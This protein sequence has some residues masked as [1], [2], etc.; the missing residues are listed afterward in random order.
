MLAGAP[1]VTTV[2]PEMVP[3]GPWIPCGPCGPAG[4]AGPAAPAAPA[5]PAGPA[6]PA[7]PAGPAAPAGPWDP[8][9]LEPCG[10]WGPA[11]PW[12]PCI[13]C[14]PAGPGGPIGPIG[15]AGPA[16]PVAP[17]APGVPEPHTL[18]QLQTLS[19]PG[20]PVQL[21][22]PL[23][24]LLA[25]C[26]RDAAVLTAGLVLAEAAVAPTPTSPAMKAVIPT[27]VTHANRRL[28]QVFP[29]DRVSKIVASMASGRNLPNRVTNHNNP[30][31]NGQL[32]T[33]ACPAPRRKSGGGRKYRRVLYVS[34][35]VVERSLAEEEALPP[36][37]YDRGRRGDSDSR[38]G[39]RVGLTSRD[40]EVLRLLADGRTT[41]DIAQVLAYSESTVKE[42]VYAILQSLGARNRA[43]AVALAIRRPT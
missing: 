26:G 38:P 5:G 22:L 37:W 4:P 29:P 17:V 16:G 8:E 13:P 30:C 43:H 41:A 33:A 28:M 36:S 32:T 31:P 3:A 20:V 25:V 6:A 39:W 7:G 9:P 21:L 34:S 27:N 2:A 23:Q 19:P 14:A 42:L 10:P 11:G 24:T 1:E 18:L 40:V 35:G 15:P 12:R